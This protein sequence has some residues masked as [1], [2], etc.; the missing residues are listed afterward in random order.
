MENKSLP[1]IFS[2]LPQV[3]EELKQMQANP[4]TVN[5]DR[6]LEILDQVMGNFENIKPTE[7]DEN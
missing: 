2:Y 7:Q 3:E 4:E 1:E 5:V 6:L